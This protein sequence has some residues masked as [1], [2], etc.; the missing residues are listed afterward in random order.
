M[1]GVIGLVVTLMT[2]ASSLSTSFLVRKIGVGWLLTASTT[3]TALSLLGFSQAS[4]VIWL[5][6]FAIPLGLGAGA[7]DSALNDY[8]ARHYA[9]HHMNWLHAFW[10]VGAT[11]GPIIFA[12][13]LAQEGDWHEGYMRLGAIQGVII[14]LLVCA[15]PLWSKVKQRQPTEENPSLDPSNITFKMLLKDRRALYS[16]TTFLL[17]TGIE[18]GIGLWLASYLVAI[19][20]TS[21]KTAAL[22]AGLYYGAIT[23][24]RIVTGFVSFKVATTTLIRYGLVVAL[25]GT[26][27]LLLNVQ[28]AVSLVGIV[29]IGCGFAPV[30]PGLI[31]STPRRFGHAKASK[32]MSLQMVGGYVGASIIPPVIGLLAGMLSMRVF[33]VAT[34]AILV[35]VIA[36]TEI[37]RKMDGELE[38]SRP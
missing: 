35:T 27:L 31:H 15:L 21:V 7:I 32:V 37:L 20:S 3:L 12:A 4:S 17:Y 30:F 14:L 11:L 29:L 9:A 24:G 18:I 25:C 2:I 8:V 13:S 19:Q 36:T 10:G 1:G 23:V 26:T 28:P 34:P 38:P 33:A 5:A 22:W 6:L 16:T